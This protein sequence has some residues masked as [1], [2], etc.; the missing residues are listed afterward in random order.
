MRDNSINTMTEILCGAAILG[1]IK[2]ISKVAYLQGTRDGKS[3]R[4]RNAKEHYFDE[5]GEHFVY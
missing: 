1:V 3:E 4:D 2:F 5:D